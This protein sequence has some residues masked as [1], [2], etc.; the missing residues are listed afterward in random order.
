MNEEHAPDVSSAGPPVETQAE[1]LPVVNAIIATA[2]SAALKR[3]TEGDVGLGVIAALRRLR[4]TA[5]EE[6]GLSVVAA[7]D[8]VIRS[9]LLAENLTRLRAG[10]AAPDAIV[11]PAPGRGANAAAA[12]FES[13]ADSC[14]AVN[15]HAP[16]NGPLELAVYALTGQMVQRFGGTPAWPALKDELD[17]PLGGH[18]PV[19]TSVLPI[20]GAPMH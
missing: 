9:R 4:A 19:P 3:G 16:D 15:A 1:T 5:Q 7:I 10:G 2:A 18:I 20:E 8:T 6:A 12:I 17:R 14:L 11:I 13:A